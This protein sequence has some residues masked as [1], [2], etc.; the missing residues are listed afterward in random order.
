MKTIR[1]WTVVALLAVIGCG[2]RAETTQRLWDGKSFAGW[3]TIGRGSW[4][5]VDGAIRGIHPADEPEFSHLVTD[6]SYRDFTVRLKFKAVKGNSGFYFR[7]AEQGFSGVTGFQAEIDAKVDVGGLYETN[8]RAWVVQPTPEQVASWFKPG[9]WNE[10]TV[11]AKGG[12]VVVHV[13]G[14]KS[15]ELR[16][17]PGR[18]EGKLALQVHG[19]QDVE[20]WFKDLEI[21]TPEREG[22]TG[23]RR[24]IGT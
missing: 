14:Y 10:M 9:E 7:I 15:A 24:T 6:R 16:N 13:N 1:V 5:I 22:R 19:G 8:G 17:D 21:V 18:A 20:V 4:T 2:V 11:T 3:H 23:D 12:D